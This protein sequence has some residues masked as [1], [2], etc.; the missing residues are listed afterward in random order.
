MSPFFWSRFI[1]WLEQ[2]IQGD[3]PGPNLDLS[4][5][6][7]QWYE[8]RDS[9]ERQRR[10]NNL[11]EACKELPRLIVFLGNYIPSSLGYDHRFVLRGAPELPEVVFSTS[12]VYGRSRPPIAMVRPFVYEESR[13][14]RP[15]ASS[16]TA[17]VCVSVA[18][19]S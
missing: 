8:Q 3:Y 14:R 19:I 4:D 10:Y 6:V 18:V 7:N 13:W 11:P 12:R 15:R 9:Q 16:L 17:V 5:L 1:Q 2:H